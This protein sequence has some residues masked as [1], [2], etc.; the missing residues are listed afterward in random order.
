M[1]LIAVLVIEVLAM[2]TT[3]ILV[4]VGVFVVVLYPMVTI[5]IVVTIAIITPSKCFFYETTTNEETPGTSTARLVIADARGNP[6]E[7]TP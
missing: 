2:T 1:V 5:I 4:L 3:I 7:V 6:G